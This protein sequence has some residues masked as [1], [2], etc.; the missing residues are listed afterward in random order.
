MNKNS[1]EIKNSELEFNTNYIFDKEKQSIEE[2]IGLIFK[3]YIEE[4]KC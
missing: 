1:I 3:D 4:V 2:T